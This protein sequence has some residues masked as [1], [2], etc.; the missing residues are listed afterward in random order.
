MTPLSQNPQ[1]GVHI[2]TIAHEGLIWDAFLDFEDHMHPAAGY[3][4]RFRFE[5]PS[6]NEGPPVTATAA[7]II[8]N[9]YE[10]AV[11][12]ARSFDDRQLQALLRSTLPEPS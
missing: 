8:E 5:P 6:G 3:R 1:P 11:A 2:A 4:A 9:S 10:E 12:K 7:I